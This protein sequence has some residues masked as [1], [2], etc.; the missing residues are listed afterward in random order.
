MKMHR[1]ESGCVIGPEN[2]LFVG[3]SEGA[4]KG[5]IDC[6]TRG[7]EGFNRLSHKSA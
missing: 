6:R 5:L 2:I 1:V 7:S 4:V 3:A